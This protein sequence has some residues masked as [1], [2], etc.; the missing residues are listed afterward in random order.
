MGQLTKLKQLYLHHNRLSYIPESINKLSDLKVFRIND[1]YLSEFPLQILGLQGLKNLDISSNQIAS[2][3]EDIREF[4]QLEIFYF[5]NNPT[6]FS[7]PENAH[8]VET[9]NAMVKRGAVVNPHS[10]ERK[11]R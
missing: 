6:N 2:I 7:G 11:A 5:Q 8:I 4:D 3:P 9:V 1:N 10:F